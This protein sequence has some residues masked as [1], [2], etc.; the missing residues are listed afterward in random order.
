M[1]KIQTWNV[2]LSTRANCLRYYIH[3]FT[4]MKILEVSD[5][6]S[7]PIITR[8]KGMVC[9]VENIFETL[10]VLFKISKLLSSYNFSSTLELVRY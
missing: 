9:N 6:T 1:H 8:L 7:Q 2:W 4:F 3:Y 10:W 5:N